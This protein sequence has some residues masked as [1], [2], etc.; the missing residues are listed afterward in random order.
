M[1]QVVRC[2]Q[3]DERRRRGERGTEVDT[4]W[5]RKSEEEKREA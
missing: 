1:K 4:Y 3:G 2:E 5:W